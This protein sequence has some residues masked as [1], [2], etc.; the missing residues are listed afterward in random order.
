MKIE[1]TP[2]QEKGIQKAEEERKEICDRIL[3]K[4]FYKLVESMR[5]AQKRYFNNGRKQSDLQ[6]S[7]DLEYKVDKFLKEK[8]SNQTSIF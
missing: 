4:D 2:E 7:K 5:A 8:D 3:A 6:D 1:T